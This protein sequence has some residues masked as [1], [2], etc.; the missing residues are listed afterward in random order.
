[1]RILTEKIIKLKAIFFAQIFLHI[2]YLRSNQKMVTYLINANEN[3]V[4]ITWVLKG[5]VQLRGLG[6]WPLFVVDVQAP[7][8]TTTGW[9]NFHA[10]PGLQWQ[11][12][13]KTRTWWYGQTIDKIAPNT[14]NKF[15]FFSHESVKMYPLIKNKCHA[16]LMQ[17]C[18]AFRIVMWGL[19]KFTY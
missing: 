5:Q 9:L 12:P 10:L 17:C 6:S 1:M 4:E 13:A 8:Q 7:L 16:Y 3:G 19:Q 18:I 15:Y 2:L 11:Q 14:C